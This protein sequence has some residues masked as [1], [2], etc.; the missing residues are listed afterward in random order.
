MTQTLSIVAVS[1]VCLTTVVVGGLGLRL[2]RRTS[3]F[4]VAGRTVV[5]SPQ[6]ER[7]LGR[8]LSAASF[9]GVG[10]LIYDEGMDALAP[11]GYTGRYLV[12]LVMVCGTMRRSGPTAARLRRGAL[13][14]IVSRRLPHALPGRRHRLAV[15]VPQF[16]GPGS[17]CSS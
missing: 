7:D 6:R 9:L 15:L 1:L 12:L 4:Y 2:S 11:G 8:V 10:E 13:R 16:R 17:R 5:A 14:S 3:D